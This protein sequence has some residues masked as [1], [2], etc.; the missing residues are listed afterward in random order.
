MAKRFEVFFEEYPPATASKMLDLAVDTK[1]DIKFDIWQDSPAGALNGVEYNADSL[2]RDY[3]GLTDEQ[4]AHAIGAAIAVAKPQPAFNEPYLIRPHHVIVP[5][6]R[7][8]TGRNKRHHLR[9]FPRFF[10]SFRN[11]IANN[12]PI[13]RIHEYAL[14]RPILRQPVVCLRK[15]AAAFCVGIVRAWIK[16]KIKLAVQT[17]KE[18]V[19]R[20]PLVRF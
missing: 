15:I 6:S 12:S 14:G 3:P 2:K 4:A 9:A 20:R 18:R 17:L 1:L 8:G 10:V 19:R 16:R 5:I 13:R 7:I 11:P